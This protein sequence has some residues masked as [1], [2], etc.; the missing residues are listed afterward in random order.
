[1]LSYCTLFL[2]K[3]EV[4]KFDVAA[5]T[6][7][8]NVIWNLM[9]SP[10]PMMTEVADSSKMSTYLPDPVCY[11]SLKT[12][13]LDPLLCCYILALKLNEFVKWCVIWSLWYVKC[14]FRRINSCSRACSKPMQA[15]ILFVWHLYCCEFKFR[16]IAAHT[17]MR[18]SLAA[19]SAF[20]SF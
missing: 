10:Q 1:M 11:I 16:S 12:V 13:L 18:G 19:A 7:R 5:V 20:C 6:G 14:Q 15:S 9:G 3:N 2:D 4:L 8:W 17:L